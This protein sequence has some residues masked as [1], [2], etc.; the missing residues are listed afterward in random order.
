MTGNARHAWGP[1]TD[2]DAIKFRLWAPGEAAVVLQLA[3]AAHEMENTGDG[4]FETRV[5]G[6]LEG[7]DYVFVLG[8]GRAVPDPAS[9]QQRGDVHGPSLVPASGY[10]WRTDW[11]GRD[12]EEAV[13]SEIHV[14][15]FTSEGT[16]SSAIGKLD[17]LAETGITAIEMMPV[18]QFSGERGWGY[19]GVLHY[20][21][22]SAYGTPDDFRAFIDAAHARGIMVLLDVV[23]NHF[24]P[25]GNYLHGYT[26]DFFRADRQTP[27]GAAID[28]AQPAVRRYFIDNAL[29]WIG[30]FQL[31]GLRLDAVEQIHDLSERHVLEELSEEV[32][33]AF[34]GRKVHL[35]VE[36]QR[37]LV[38]LL[39]RDEKGEVKT[40]TA[41]WNDDFHHV[42]HI[43]ATGEDNGHYKPFAADLWE[44]T[45][46]ALQ[47]GFVYP[48][49]ADPPELPRDER[50]YLPPEAFVNFLQNHDQIGNRAFGERLLSLSRPPMVETLTAIMMLAPQIPFLF[51]G[52]EYGE[53]QPFYFFC[54]YA[55]ELGDMIRKGRMT[56]AEG[57]GGLKEGQSKE[58]LPDPNARATFDGSALQ[59]QRAE[60]VDGRRRK[61]F[62]AELARIR[63]QHVVPLLKRTPRMQAEAL[64]TGDGALA[65][66]WAMDGARL[67]LRANLTS[68]PMTLPAV[69]GQTIFELIREAH[70]EGL[71]PESV[72][73]ALA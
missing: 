67:Q 44:K 21:P 38:S 72:V 51:M 23:Y 71:P 59:W 68:L 46:L 42:A 52:E 62:V 41:E 6:P 70:G 27:W 36:D 25:E 30:E 34:P 65:I 7:Q 54:D 58:T 53:T 49:R 13:I 24:G 43:I 50:V 48:D 19:D 69:N 47:H 40:Y 33:A 26:P 29:Y 45:K 56:E 28:F 57:F 31:D 37:N 8:D 12:W 1:Q 60:A 64:E 4:W 9:R 55:G 63:Q 14:G 5:S 10:R 35:V 61:A 39:E 22:H 3:G 11:K 32:R 66:D 18:A 16:F 17:H 73:F 2:G 15:T 20:A